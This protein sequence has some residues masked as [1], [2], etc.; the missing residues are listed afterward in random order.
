M[1][2][3]SGSS[4]DDSPYQLSRARRRES[5]SAQE[6]NYSLFNM[7]LIKKFHNARSPSSSPSGNITVADSGFESPKPFNSMTWLTY[8]FS[9]QYPYII[10]QTGSE[11]AQ[12]YQVKIGQFTV[13]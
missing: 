3:S 12:T 5:N 13:V 2:F 6:E 7:E 9:L 8:N 11:N 1:F 4:S 10:Q